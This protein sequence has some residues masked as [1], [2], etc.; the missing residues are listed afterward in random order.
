MQKA[1]IGSKATFHFANSKKVFG[2][3]LHI[4]QA[5]GDSWIIEEIYEGSS[6]QTYYIQQFDYMILAKT[7]KCQHHALSDY[8]GLCHGCNKYIE[9]KRK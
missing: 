9:S 3:I 5:T 2:E 1:D 7:E 4:P 8:G 6:G